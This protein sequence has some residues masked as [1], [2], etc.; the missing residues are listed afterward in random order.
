MSEEREDLL[1]LA[2]EV[3]EDEGSSMGRVFS[4]LMR[5]ALTEVVP[6]QARGGLPVF[7]GAEESGCLKVMRPSGGCQGS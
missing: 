5:E 1:S 4:D 2:K 6:S 3:A 7:E